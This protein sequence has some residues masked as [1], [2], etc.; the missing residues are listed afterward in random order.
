MKKILI[1]TMATLA[2][3]TVTFSPAMLKG[4]SGEAWEE[5]RADVARACKKLAPPELKNPSIAVDE[6][7]SES[8]GIAILTGTQD[9]AHAAYVCVYH[10]QSRK[11]E[12]SGP[13]DLKKAKKIGR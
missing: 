12:L 6:Y 4:S 1:F 10:K 7:G 11:A 13:I 2:V 5:F 9:G 3:V 8:Y